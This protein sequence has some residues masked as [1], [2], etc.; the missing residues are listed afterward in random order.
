MSP[1]PPPPF[2]RAPGDQVLPQFWPHAFI[3]QNVPPLR[4]GAAVSG[5][6]F[7]VCLALLCSPRAWQDVDMGDNGQR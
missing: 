3:H 4:R 6:E 7:L 5:D 1:P 2:C